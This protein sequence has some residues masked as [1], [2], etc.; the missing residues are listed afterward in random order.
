M[1]DESRL[2]TLHA[3]ELQLQKLQTVF[4]PLFLRLL[5]S[6]EEGT[7][8]NAIK[9]Y[10]CMSELVN[11]LFNKVIYFLVSKDYAKIKCA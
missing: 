4:S 2:F 7:G 3:V 6:N 9:D 8:A 11:N 10:E 1:K 5:Q